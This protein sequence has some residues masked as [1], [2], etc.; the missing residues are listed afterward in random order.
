M[1]RLSI[2]AVLLVALTGHA[3]ADVRATRFSENPLITLA[4][5]RTI[6]DNA[7]GP[8]AAHHS[9]DAWHVDRGLTLAGAT[10]RSDGLA[11]AAWIRT[12]H[13][14]GRVQGW[15]HVHQSPGNHAPE[16]SACLPPPATVLRDGRLGQLLRAT[17]PLAAFELGDSPFRDTPYHGRVRHVSAAPAST[18]SSLQSETRPSASVTRRWTSAETGAGGRSAT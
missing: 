17:D 13:A 15:T 10:I 7:N 2:C 14:G 11:Q 12:V 16:L 4:M 8:A 6:G 5:S 9:V 18:S 3:R 1:I